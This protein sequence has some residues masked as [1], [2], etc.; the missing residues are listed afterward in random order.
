MVMIINPGPYPSF[1][2]LIKGVLS[3]IDCPLNNPVD[4]TQSMIHLFIHFQQG[5]VR[6]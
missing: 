5:K 1:I 4:N 2:M 3:G 6:W